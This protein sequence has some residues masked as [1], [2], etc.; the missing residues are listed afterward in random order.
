VYK[1][2]QIADLFLNA[3]LMGSIRIKE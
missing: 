1:Y 2:K 3:R